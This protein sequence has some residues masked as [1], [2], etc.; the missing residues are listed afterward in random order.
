MNRQDL[1]AAKAYGEALAKAASELLKAEGRTE[2]VDNATAVTWRLVGA[3]ASA[4]ITGTQLTIMDPQQ[5]FQWM[6]A[7]GY[8]SEIIT[9]FAPRNPEWLKLWLENMAK[10]VAGGKAE[11][12]PGTKLT[13]GGQFKT[14]SVTVDTPVKLAL[15]QQVRADLLVGGKRAVDSE[16][17]WERA[18]ASAAQPEE[19]ES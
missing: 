18:V 2:W 8:E 14:L 17:A 5:L 11:A 4:S 19:E 9:V 1:V 15:E 6:H 12:P 7:S 13:E 16:M 10:Q 3:T